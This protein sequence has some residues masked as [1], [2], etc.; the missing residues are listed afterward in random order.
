[1]ESQNHPSFSRDEPIATPRQIKKVLVDITIP[2]HGAIVFPYGGSMITR[3]QCLLLVVFFACTISAKEALDAETAARELADPNSPLASLNLKNQWISFKGDLPDAD[4]QNGQISLFRPLMPLPLANGDKLFFRPA[5]PFISKQP[6][7]KKG[8]FKNKSGLGDI[9]FDLTYA[10]KSKGRF[11]YSFGVAASLPTATDDDL[12]TKKVTL[13]PEIFAGIKARK[14]IVGI[15]PNHQWDIAGGGNKSVSKTTAQVIGVMLPGGGW[16]YGS[17]P[18]MTYDW[19]ENQWQ[20]PINFILNK[21]VVI[22]K[23]PWRFGIELNY[24]VEQADAFGPSWSVGV[25]IAPV[26]EN[27]IAIWFKQKTITP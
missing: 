9:T 13:G 11:I 8:R 27:I 20:V 22:K 18:T 25:N 7:F 21:T 5:I 6:V 14:Y 2:L 4:N 16:S 17:V 19:I 1:M 23:R 26:V 10:P 12:S 24:F 3:Y 15:Y